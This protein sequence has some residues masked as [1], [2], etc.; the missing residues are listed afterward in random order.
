[1]TK[2]PECEHRVYLDCDNETEGICRWY[3]ACV[4]GSMH[5]MSC[6]MVLKAEAC[7]EGWR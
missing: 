5:H 2:L 1:M 4:Y 7:P 3:N 6:R